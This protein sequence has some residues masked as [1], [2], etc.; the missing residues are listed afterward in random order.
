LDVVKLNLKKKEKY[1]LLK[2][3]NL[4]NRKKTPSNNQTQNLLIIT[5]FIKKSCF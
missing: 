2:A 1:P 5:D 3:F 4:K